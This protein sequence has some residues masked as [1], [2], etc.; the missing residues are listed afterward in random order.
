MNQEQKDRILSVI[1]R[2]AAIRE[3]YI[4]IKGETCVIGGLVEEI[5]LDLWCLYRTKKNSTRIQSLYFSQ[6]LQR[7]FGLSMGRVQDLQ[8][9]ND[10]N[11]IRKVRKEKLRDLVNSWEVS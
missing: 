6:E 1:D 2:D 4:N 7:A 9:C 3:K 10:S 8:N 5:G 11:S